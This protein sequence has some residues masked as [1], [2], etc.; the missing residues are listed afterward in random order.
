MI[1][2]EHELVVLVFGGR[3]FSDRGFLFTKLDEL[4]T[5]RVITKIIH[6]AAPGADTLAGQ[7]A[8]ARGVD[9][10]DFPADWADLSHP[11]CIPRR[12]ADG[13]WYDVRAGYR[14][15]KRMRDEGQPHLGVAFP[16]GKG[17]AQMARLLEENGIEVIR[18]G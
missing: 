9:W 14:R 15:N 17:T 5:C 2:V 11:D 7:W 6:G 12:R 3:K 16:G 1:H 4:H 10:Q 13:V 8:C 18:Y